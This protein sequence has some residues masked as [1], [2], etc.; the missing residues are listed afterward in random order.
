MANGWSTS[1]ALYA[2]YALNASTGAT[3]WSFDA[4]E[5][6]SPVVANEMVYFGSDIQTV[7]A[8]NASTGAA[9][10]NFFYTSRPCDARSGRWGGLS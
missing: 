1:G 3:L 5:I 7:F 9:L 6:T 2:A 8:L 10:W 4:D